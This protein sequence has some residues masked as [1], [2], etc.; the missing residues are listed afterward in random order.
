MSSPNESKN[1]EIEKGDIFFFYRPK[2]DVKK[3]EDLDDV[4]RFYMILASENM[5]EKK[6]K[7]NFYRLFLLGR[8]KLPNI[9]EGKSNPS[10]RNWAFNILTTTNPTDL[11]EDLLT[12]AEY[13]TETKGHDRIMPA[14]IP[15]GEGKYSISKHDNHTELAYILELSE[16][17]GPSQSEFQIKKEA[18]Y[19]ISIKNP[20]INIPAFSSFSNKIPGYPEKL[21]QLFGDKRWISAESADLLNY[22]NT[23]LLLIGARKKDVEEELGI[24]IDEEAENEKTAELLAKLHIDKN[25]IPVKALLTGKFPLEKEIPPIETQQE[26]KH[27]SKYEAPGKGGKK[28]GKIA[29]E[30]SLSAFTIAKALSGIDLPKSKLEVQEFVRKSSGTQLGEIRKR[31]ILDIIDKIKTQKYYSMSDIEKEIGRVL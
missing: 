5:V 14:A 16:K 19:I 11:Q 12:S 20:E 1:L 22:E 21:K 15:T 7:R 18:S 10:E 26:I 4:Q 9:I 6:N 24:E 13:S 23:Q 30:S 29:A 3:V 27:L 31:S 25:R 8:K 28:G 17:P 2:V